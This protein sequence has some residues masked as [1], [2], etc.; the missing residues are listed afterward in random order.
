[1]CTCPPVQLTVLAQNRGRKTETVEAKL[2]HEKVRGLHI[3]FPNGKKSVN[4]FVEVPHLLSKNVTSN[5][6]VREQAFAVLSQRN[7]TIF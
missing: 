6:K 2:Q 4:M 1:M 5:E 7:K 3:K